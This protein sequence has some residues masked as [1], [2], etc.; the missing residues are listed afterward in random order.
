MPLDIKIESPKENSFTPLYLKQLQ[1]FCRATCNSVFQQLPIHDPMQPY[2]KLNRPY[3]L[4]I[5]VI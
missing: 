4:A 3:L 1:Q 2:Q 5:K